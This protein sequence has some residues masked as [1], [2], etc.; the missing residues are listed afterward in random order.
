VYWAC[1]QTEPRREAAAQH[2]LGLAGYQTYLPRLRLLRPSRGG[3]KIETRPVLFPSYLF[4]WIAAGWW[5]AR[6][7][8]HVVRLLTAGD[9]PMHVPAAVV[10]EI[11]A[12]ER[13]GLVEL[14]KPPGLKPGDRVRVLAGPFEGHLALYSGMR[15]RERVLVLLALLGSERLVELAKDAVEAA[16]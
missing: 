7:C 2:L 13:D 5:T 11:K 12:R 15:P 9:G 4:V 6:W 3:R 8:P 10:D 16:G 1:A 14:P